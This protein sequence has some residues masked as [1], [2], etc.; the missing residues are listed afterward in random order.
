M[1][2][3]PGQPPQLLLL[4]CHLGLASAFN[5]DTENVVVWSGESGSLFGFSLAMHRQLEPQDRRLGSQLS[6]AITVH[7]EDAGTGLQDYKSVVNW[8]D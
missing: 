7:L 8:L 6:E 4:L 1:A 3:A 5:L 2:R